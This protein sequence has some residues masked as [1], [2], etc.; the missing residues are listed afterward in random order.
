M[1][2]KSIIFAI[3]VCVGMLFGVSFASELKFR[4]KV[5]REESLSYWDRVRQ[6]F[7]SVVYRGKS[8]IGEGASEATKAAIRS[9]AGGST[10]IL[11][12]SARAGSYGIGSALLTSGGLTSVK[13]AI[14]G[15]LSSSVGGGLSVASGFA[16]QSLVNDGTIT[17]DQ[18]KRMVLLGGGAIALGVFS[19]AVRKIYS[20][21]MQKTITPEEASEQIKNILMSILDNTQE[22]PTIKTKLDALVHAQDMFSKAGEQGNLLAL[23]VVMQL[24]GELMQDR[25]F[26]KVNKMDALC[27]SIDWNVDKINELRKNY[28]EDENKALDQ[29]LIDHARYAM[30]NE[31]SR[32]STERDASKKLENRI[33][34]LENHVKAIKSILINLKSEQSLSN[35]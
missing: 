2:N 21:L 33:N 25:L 4:K 10:D 19:A 28:N 5:E 9:A 15:D 12:S 7:K 22:F 20:S 11:H 32:I 17:S 27:K 35:E 14:S 34:Y 26:I 3:A 29:A 23:E 18:M 13:A 16:I 6:L 24:V 30:I 1:Q 8:A 31:L